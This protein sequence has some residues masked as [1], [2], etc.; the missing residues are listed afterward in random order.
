[1]RSTLAVVAPAV[2]AGALMLSPRGHASPLV[3]VA[4]TIPTSSALVEKVQAGTVRCRKLRETCANRWGWRTF[5]Y[6]SC[7]ALRACAPT[8]RLRVLK[9]N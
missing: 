6:R 4:A 3:H 2:F 7:L 5:R 1:M 9:H 8:T